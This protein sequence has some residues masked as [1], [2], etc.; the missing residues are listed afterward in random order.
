[1]QTNLGPPF[2]VQNISDFPNGTP[3]PVLANP[4]PGSPSG[5]LINT[6]VIP[7][8]A[9]FAGVVGNINTA[10]GRPIFVNDS[11]QE[12]A[13]FERTTPPIGAANCAIALA[14][15]TAPPLNFHSPYTQQW[16]LMLQRQLLRGWALEVGYVGSHYLRGI[17]IYNPYVRLASPAGPISVTDINGVAY[18]ITTNTVLNEP[19]RHGLPGLARSRG[20]RFSGNVGFAIYHSMQVTLSHRFQGGLFFQGAYTWSKTID[21]VSGSQST[22]ELNVTR[23]GQGGANLFNLGNINPGLNRARGDFDRPHRAVF[24]W[25]YDLPVPKNGI[26]GTQAFQGWGMSGIVYFQNGLPFSVTDP[27]GGGAYARGGLSTPM[28]APGCSSP[29]DA[30]TSGRIQDRINGY[31]GKQCFAPAPSAPNSAGAGATS[32]GNIG[33]N[34]YRGP[35]QQSVDF[36]V[37]KHF[38]LAERHSL[39]FRT[40]FFNLFNHPIFRA[41][42]VNTYNSGTFGQITETAIPARIIQFGLKYEH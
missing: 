36:S 41:P 40:D 15:F 34:A 28:L 21:N 25:T 26:W 20:A 17:G 35:F 10:A 8:R 3:A 12:C 42:S 32:Y 1:L 24:S 11:G 33:R 5:S 38:R 4:F 23:S 16:N 22:D 14:S 31:L 39:T 37:L 19:L 30:Q 27:N 29:A 13:G 6:S 9:R 7:Q 2:N 18:S